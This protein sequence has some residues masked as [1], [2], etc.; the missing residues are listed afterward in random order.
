MKKKT[1]NSVTIPNS[2]TTIGTG[3]FYSNQL[4][5]VT[6]GAGITSINVLDFSGGTITNSDTG[7]SYGPNALEIVYINRGSS[8]V[9]L[10]T[11]V[12]EW[13]SGYNQTNNLHWNS[14]GPSN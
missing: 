12:F 1:I 13:A 4:T 8:D 14:T 6:I 10:G 11:N 9:T 7:I 3:A 2:I 5:S